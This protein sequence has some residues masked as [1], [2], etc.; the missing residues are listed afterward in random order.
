MGVINVEEAVAR[1]PKSVVLDIISLSFAVMISL[2]GDFLTA[3]QGF[4]KKI[5]NFV[6]QVV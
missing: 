1:N 4:A 6:F 2:G 3:I 5:I